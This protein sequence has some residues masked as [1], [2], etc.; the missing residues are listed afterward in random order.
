MRT[1]KRLLIFFVGFLFLPSFLEGLLRL[2]CA[3]V[4]YN[5]TV[6][7]QVGLFIVVI[8]LFRNRLY[9]KVRPVVRASRL[10]TSEF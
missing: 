7:V 4:F 9:Y 2:P 5:Q 10:D 3:P 8:Y 1:I 6:L